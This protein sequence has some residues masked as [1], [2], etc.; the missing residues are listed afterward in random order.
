MQAD[1]GRPILSI[2]RL[3]RGSRVRGGGGRQCLAQW[4]AAGL[5]LFRDFLKQDKPE[6]D[7]VQQFCTSIL[8]ISKWCTRFARRFTRIS[9]LDAII[10]GKSTRILLWRL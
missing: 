4:L 5:S 2:S 3:G 8:F 9:T 6:C 7:V 10:G 1:S